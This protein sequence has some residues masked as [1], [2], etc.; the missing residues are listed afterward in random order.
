MNLVINPID[1]STILQI[2]EFNAAF[3]V[4][5][6]ALSFAVFYNKKNENHPIL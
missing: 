1:H 2:L 4:L 5:L 3:L 6:D